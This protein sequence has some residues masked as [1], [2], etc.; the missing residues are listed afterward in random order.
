MF[1][2]TG[3]GWIFVRHLNI[4]GQWNCYKLLSFPLPQNSIPFE[5]HG[6]QLLVSFRWKAAL[7]ECFSLDTKTLEGV[8]KNNLW[9]RPTLL[10]LLTLSHSCTC[11]F[12]SGARGSFGYSL[13]LKVNVLPKVG[14]IAAVPL[15]LLSR[16]DKK[17]SL[18]SP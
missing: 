10:L 2:T 17:S 5:H 13:D 14:T 11:A 1:A 15:G 12:W 3:L 9:K 18:K 8:G 4:L 7:G 16:V 6:K